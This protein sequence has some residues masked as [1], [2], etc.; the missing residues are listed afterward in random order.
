MDPFVLSMTISQCA[1]RCAFQA[2]TPLGV[3]DTLTQDNRLVHPTY[4]IELDPVLPLVALLRQ[5]L[6]PVWAFRATLNLCGNETWVDGGE[7][8]GR[9]GV[10]P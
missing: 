4:D 6:A 10:V 5:F 1:A 7:S 2:N 9:E 3:S 8:E